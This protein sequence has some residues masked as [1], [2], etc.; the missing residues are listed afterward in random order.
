[1]AAGKKLLEE[2]KLPLL[3][4]DDLGDAAQKVVR[5]AQTGK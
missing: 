4:A 2:S 3:T 5:A 1:V